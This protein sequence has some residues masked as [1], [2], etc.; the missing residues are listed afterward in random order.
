MSIIVP[1]FV[2]P[3]KT[4]YYCSAVLYLRLKSDF[5]FVP[6]LNYDFFSNWNDNEDFI[7]PAICSIYKM[8]TESQ[9]TLIKPK[10]IILWY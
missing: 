10:Q 9:E 8:S 3:L 2:F 1:F 4:L 6:L 5:Y 7:K